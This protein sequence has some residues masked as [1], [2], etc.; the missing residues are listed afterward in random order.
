[1]VI[2]YFP[3]RRPVEKD[4]YP[5]GNKSNISLYDGSLVKLLLTVERLPFR[6]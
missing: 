3:S 6:N 2:V 1:M 5:E 4:S